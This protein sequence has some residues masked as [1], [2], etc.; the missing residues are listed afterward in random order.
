[1]A[2]D[3]EAAAMATTSSA[4]GALAVDAVPPM[5]LGTLVTYISKVGPALLD[6]P[7]D[8]FVAAIQQLAAQK[9]V[10]QFIVDARHSVLVMSNIIT[11]DITSAVE[12]RSIEFELQ[13]VFRPASIVSSVAFIKR[14]ANSIINAS[15]SAASQ[16]QV[17]NLGNESPYDLLH[18]YLQ[19]SLAPFVRSFSKAQH[20]DVGSRDHTCMFLSLSLSL[21]LSLIH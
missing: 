12:T 10:Q 5:D 13:V 15:H 11:S 14:V 17:I 7:D 18:T 6:V 3:P 21:S 2:D 19:N 9:A 1:M 4:S 16:L 8:E 20:E